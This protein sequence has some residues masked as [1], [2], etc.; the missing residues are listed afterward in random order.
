MIVQEILTSVKRSFGDESGVQVQ[1]S[2]IIRWINQGMREIVMQ[3]EGLLLVSSLADALASTQIYT[4]PSNL[5]ILRSI[6]YKNAS[7]GQYFKMKG[8]D[9]STF[10]TVV[11]GWEVTPDNLGDPTVYTIVDTT[12]NTFAVYPAPTDNLTDAFKIYYNRAP[13]EVTTSTDTPELPIIYH[14]VLIKHCMLQAYELDEDWE[15]AGN[16]ATQL[17]R[18]INLLRGREDWKSQE[19]YPTINILWE[20]EW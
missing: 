14:E 11:D 16:K 4:L 13:V 18:D 19:T 15:A 8:Y 1:D 9:L 2:D 6:K 10:N 12:N 7:T 17:D 5:L 20:D 3:N